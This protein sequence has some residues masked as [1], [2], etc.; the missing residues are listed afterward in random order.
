MMAVQTQ[1]RRSDGEKVA[2]VAGIEVAIRREGR[3]FFSARYGCDRLVVG[4]RYR[5]EKA[6]KDAAV[7]YALMARTSHA[8][9]PLH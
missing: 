1:W 8:Q 3:A 2:V 7:R 6:A 5:T 9:P 4:R